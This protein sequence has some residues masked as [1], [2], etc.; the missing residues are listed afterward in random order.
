M[1]TE[2]YCPYC[3]RLLPVKEIMFRCVGRIGPTGKKC[4]RSIDPVLSRQTGDSASKFPA[5]S[6]DGRKPR[7]DCPR[8]LGD[9][10]ERICRHCHSTLPVHFGRADNRLIALVG[11]KESGKTVYMTV[12][13][14]ELMN[15][16]GRRLDAAVLGADDHT[17]AIFSGDYEQ[18]L[19]ERRE[20]HEQTRTAEASPTGIRP[21]VFSLGLDVR[22]FHRKQ[23][24]RTLLSFFDTAGEDLISTE[25]VAYNVRYL[26]S[27]DGIIL[28]L[29]P[30]QLKGARPLAA[31][32]SLPRPTDAGSDPMAVLDRITGLL[33]VSAATKKHGLIKKPLAVVFS[34]MDTMDELLPQE[35]HVQ[36]YSSTKVI[37]DEADSRAVDAELRQLLYDWHGSLMEKLLDKNYERYRFFGVSALGQSPICDENGAQRVSGDLLR[38]RRVHDPFL[39][40]LNEFH[41]L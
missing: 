16:V 12:L 13:L 19:Y 1:A 7:A 40:L 8:C 18:R 3:Y 22:R 2:L 15:E 23:L 31:L 30:L 35:F 14:H 27:A 41:T 20:M 24:R 10:T 37:F 5:F 6:A 29:D 34:K 9:S 26:N 33:H 11:A 38:P 25:S 21:L 28:L 39:W 32:G 17:R 36:R 4:E